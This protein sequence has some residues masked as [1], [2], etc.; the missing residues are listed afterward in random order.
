MSKEEDQYSSFQYHISMIHTL[1]HELPEKSRKF[2]KLI[3]KI[4][5]C[6]IGSNKIFNNLFTLLE[7]YARI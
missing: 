1:D 4:L 2:R 3:V 5:N 6:K 7:K